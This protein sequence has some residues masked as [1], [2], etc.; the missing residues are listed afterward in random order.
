MSDVSG[1][2]CKQLVMILKKCF[3]IYKAMYYKS[4]SAKP[5]NQYPYGNKKG[6]LHFAVTLLDAT[7]G[8]KKS[9]WYFKTS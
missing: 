6:L 2:P 9:P 1:K 7:E 3:P 8:E 4:G 5:E